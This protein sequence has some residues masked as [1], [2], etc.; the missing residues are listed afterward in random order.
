[1]PTEATARAAGQKPGIYLYEEIGETISDY[2][3]SGSANCIKVIE[4]L[5]VTLTEVGPAPLTAPGLPAD[6][7]TERL[8]GG[9]NP[10]VLEAHQYG[11]VNLLGFGVSPSIHYENGL[12]VATLPTRLHVLSPA[13]AIPP[14]NTLVLQYIFPFVDILWDADSLELDA[15]SAAKWAEAD[16][17]VLRL[18]IQAG[19]P[20]K[21]L[22]ENP[23]EAVA[24]H[25][26][27]VCDEFFLLIDNP[28]TKE[29]EVQDFLEKPGCT[30]IVAPHNRSIYPRRA[31][32]G[33]RYIPDFIVERPDEDYNLIEI[34]SPNVNIYQPQ[35][36][37]PSSKFTHAIQQVEDWLRYI[38]ENLDSV[39]REDRLEG[40][41]KP[42]GQV[43][44]GRDSDLNESGATRFRYKRS[45][46][47]RIS[48]C[49]Y[50]MIVSEARAYAS[51]LRSM[52]TSP[53]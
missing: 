6:I 23:F 32:G 22:S 37:E 40:L 49:T 13:I 3:Q 19:I 30:F 39:R 50:D 11:K 47:S 27:K 1:M 20:P 7:E 10:T 45:E 26:D 33:N 43:V 36:Q 18:G 5:P 35:G 41:Y 8:R 4:P 24:I 21:P 48:L 12:P 38:D 44:M 34:E 25:I 52:Q 14:D 31:I 17:E 46:N 16:L 15:T 9:I 51:S 28:D 29:P 2:L 42:T 53:D